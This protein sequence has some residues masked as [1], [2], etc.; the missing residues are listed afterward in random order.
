LKI[1]E[2]RS[3]LSSWPA[4]K[5]EEVFPVD[6]TLALPRGKADC[7]PDAATAAVVLTGWL[8][9]LE[10]HELEEGLRQAKYLINSGI[11]TVD[12][13]QRET[14]DVVRALLA[15]GDTLAAADPV[16]CN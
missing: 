2:A 7:W 1:L 13:W 3:I 6:A 15:W 16:Q 11:V 8:P 10:P 5:R 14:L 4:E 12:R 9:N